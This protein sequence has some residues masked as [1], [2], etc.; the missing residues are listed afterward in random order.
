LKARSRILRTGFGI[1][2]CLIA[3]SSDAFESHRFSQCGSETSSDC[4]WMLEHVPFPNAENTTSAFDQVT[5]LPLIQSVLPI[6]FLCKYRKADWVPVPIVSVELNHQAVR[7]HK[8]VN[9]PFTENDVL[10]FVDDL[11]VIEH[12]VAKGFQLCL[13]AAL[14]EANDLRTSLRIGKTTGAGAENNTVAFL[15]ALN[16]GRS[17]YLK[18]LAAVSTDVGCSF[19]F[20]PHVGTFPRTESNAVV[21]CSTL[22]HPDRF[23]A[24][25]TRGLFSGPHPNT[26]ALV[27]AVDLGSTGTVDELFF[28]DRTRRCSASTSKLGETLLRA[29]EAPTL[30]PFLSTEVVGKFFGADQASNDH[31][32]GRFS[33]AGTVTKPRFA[34][35]VLF[36]LR[37]TY[38]AF[39]NLVRHTGLSS[40]EEVYQYWGVS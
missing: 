14:D 35:Q 30:L 18:G 15:T 28:A 40:S 38:F 27:R 37:A 10:A 26:S 2:V 11:F 4:V 36:D 12:C 16:E 29:T 9:A 6:L 24:D 39:S 21:A 8:S 23:F 33:F 34:F 22:D 3:I 19:S 5:V 31:C 17:S 32:L 7:R 13:S 20:L 25:V 1:V